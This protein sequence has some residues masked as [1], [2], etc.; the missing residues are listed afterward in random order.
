[1]DDGTWGKIRGFF[2]D[3]YLYGRIQ[4]NLVSGRGYCEICVVHFGVLVFLGVMG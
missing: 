1:M 4:G 2:D 3:T